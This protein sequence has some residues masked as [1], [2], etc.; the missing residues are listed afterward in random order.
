MTPLRQMNYINVA[1]FGLGI[2]YTNYE[3]CYNI[4]SAVLLL[5]T[6]YKITALPAEFFGGS[7]KAISNNIQHPDI[8]Y[9]GCQIFKALSSTIPIPEKQ[10]VIRTAT[11]ILKKHVDFPFIVDGVTKFYIS[12]LKGDPLSQSIACKSYA[13]NFLIYAIRRHSDDPKIVSSCCVSLSILF[14]LPSILEKYC[15][16]NLAGVIERMAGLRNDLSVLITSLS[17]ENNENIQMVVKRGQCTNS[18]LGK[19]VW[20]PQKLYRCLTCKNSKVLCETCRRVYHGNH[21]C[22]EFFCIGRC[23]TPL[24]KK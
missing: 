5:L 14:S 12:V 4:F 18:C 2:Y 11:Q 9:L 10:P 22:V 21:N 23:S 20:A 17:R 8:C 19:D 1:S 15:T 16:P 6:K 7:I 24:S 3:M 13:H